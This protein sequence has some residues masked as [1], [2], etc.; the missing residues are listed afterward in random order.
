MNL[1][2]NRPRKLSG[3]VSRYSVS[4]EMYVVVRVMIRFEK[5]SM[6]K[7]ASRTMASRRSI[8]GGP[9]GSWFMRKRNRNQKNPPPSP[10]TMNSVMK[11]AS[12]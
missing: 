7:N 1:T 6:E 11:P 5:I 8:S 9:N 4:F 10:T 3:S 2:P 12:T